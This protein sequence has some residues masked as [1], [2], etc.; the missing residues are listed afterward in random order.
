[1]GTAYTADLSSVIHALR[2]VVAK[3]FHTG[4]VLQIH[5]VF[6]GVKRKALIKGANGKDVASL[7]GLG[8]CCSK[9]C[10]NRRNWSERRPAL[11]P[12]Y[13]ALKTGKI[14]S[15]HTVLSSLRQLSMV[16]V[17]SSPAAAA[18]ASVAAG[19]SA[20]AASVLAGAAA[21]AS[22]AAAAGAAAAGASVA[23]GGGTAGQQHGDHQQNHKG[24]FTEHELFSPFNKFNIQKSINFP[25]RQTSVK[26]S[27]PY[28]R[29]YSKKG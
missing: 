13:L 19:A 3:V 18:G 6:L 28:G 23:A 9:G 15:F 29:F 7:S 12:G 26:V 20:G 10:C 2:A 17:T 24:I 25:A 4:E 1:M 14:C 11:I 22:V 16:R 21:G 27:P 5:Q 8:V